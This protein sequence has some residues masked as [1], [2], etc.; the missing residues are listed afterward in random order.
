M[1]AQRPDEVC[2]EGTWFAVTAVD[3]T[4]LF[5]PDAHGLAPEAFSTGC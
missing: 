1:T 4:G 2:F 5:D 3:G